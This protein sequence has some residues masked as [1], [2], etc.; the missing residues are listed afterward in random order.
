[1]NKKLKNQIEALTAEDIIIMSD[2]SNSMLQVWYRVPPVPV[3]HRMPRPPFTFM[4]ESR[5]ALRR[6]YGH[7]FQAAAMRRFT[8]MPKKEKP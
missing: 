2:V 8:Q 1:M 6:E 7:V 4:A 5:N 3:G